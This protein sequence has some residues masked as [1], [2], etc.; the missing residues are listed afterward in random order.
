MT[1]FS[2]NIF[3]GK[4]PLKWPFDTLNLTHLRSSLTLL[5]TKTTDLI[6]SIF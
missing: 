6:H 2:G 1:Q 4:N 3:L 5:L